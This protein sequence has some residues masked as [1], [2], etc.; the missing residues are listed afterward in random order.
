MT[1]CSS[2]P[3]NRTIAVTGTGTSEIRLY[4]GGDEI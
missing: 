2:T 1:G 4:R 3:D